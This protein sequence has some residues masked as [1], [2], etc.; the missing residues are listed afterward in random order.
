MIVSPPIRDRKIRFAL[1]GCGRIAAN[2]FAALEQH[3]ADAEIVAVCDTDPGA[4][5]KA[6]ART[7]ARGF[8]SHTEMLGACAADVVVIA[9]PSGL[10]PEQASAA[11]RPGRHVMT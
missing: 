11:A 2:H 10:H 9:T 4:L 7:G 8:A 1:T 6:V 5:D 3:A